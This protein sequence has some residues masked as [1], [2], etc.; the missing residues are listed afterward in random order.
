MVV[1]LIFFAKLQRWIN[2]IYTVEIPAILNLLLNYETREFRF[3]SHIAKEK[4]S[5]YQILLK[6]IEEQNYHINFS[7]NNNS[8]ELK[9]L[10]RKMIYL[11]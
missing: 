1:K 8:L 2:Y 3:K 11:V 6:A 5:I 7:Q 4:E 9:K 10:K